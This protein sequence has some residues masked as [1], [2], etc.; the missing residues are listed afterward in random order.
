MNKILNIRGIKF[1]E[2]A[3]R[4]PVSVNLEGKSIQISEMV[5]HPELAKI[6][7]TTF[8]PR[9]QVKL[10]LERLMLE[11]DFRILVPKLGILTKADVIRNVKNATAL[12]RRVVR[13]EL[14]YCND[15]MNALIRERRMTKPVLPKIK[16]PPVPEDWAWIPTNIWTKWQL[17]FRTRILVSAATTA[18]IDGAPDKIAKVVPSFL[19]QGFDVVVLK[20][21]DDVASIFSPIA[22]QPRTRYICGACHGNGSVFGGD[23]GNAILAVG[24]YDPKEVTGK[25]IHLQSCETAKYLGPDLVKN[26]AI[27]FAGYYDDFIIALGDPWE[28]PF[29]ACDDAFDVAMASGCT[30]EQAYDFTYW[31]FTS[32]S[33]EPP[34]PNSAAAS[35][36]QAD[37]DAF[38]SP[39]T[40]KIYGDPNACLSPYIPAGIL[41]FESFYPNWWSVHGPGPVSWQDAPKSMQGFRNHNAAEK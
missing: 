1:T 9:L 18:W 40:D 17:F 10:V 4:K 22:Q 24:Q 29:F 28:M 34:F 6:P 5:R 33:E 8:P 26:G 19:S 30:V 12:G 16:C 11:S 14:N 25:I 21:S 3:A 41:P 15:L 32:T 31:M 27:A 13:V 23:D 2:E 38:R 39:A 7:L 36:L 35:W 37:R 20:D